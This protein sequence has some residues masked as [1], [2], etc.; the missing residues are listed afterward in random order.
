MQH[1]KYVFTLIA[2]ICFAGLAFA[3]TDNETTPLL[4]TGQVFDTDGNVLEG[5]VVEIWHTDVAGV[6]DHPGDGVGDEL[7]ETFQYFGTSTVDANGNY[8]FLTYKPGQYEPRPVH[9]HVKVKL[10]SVTALITQFYFSEDSTRADETIL[11][12]IVDTVDA[13]GEPIRV[14]IG[15]IVLD[16]NGAD[17]NTLVP[18][19]LQ[20]EGPF[21]PVVDI[22]EY[23]NDLTDSD[24]AQRAIITNRMLYTRLNVNTVTRD[25]LLAI[26]SIP[27]SLIDAI[28]ANRPFNSIIE[29]W[30]LDTE[31]VNLMDAY[32]YVPIDVDNTDA[33]TIMQLDLA[34]ES[35]EVIL[36]TLASPTNEQFIAFILEFFPGYTEDDIAPYLAE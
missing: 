29:L 35:A 3:Q 6:Y 13:Q 19:A 7:D 10:E 36:E 15:D 12:D 34:Q 25:E 11:L 26:E 8:A 14:A 21:Y 24:T 5:A 30:A 33:S 17:S 31:L 32:L 20:A 1:T 22:S 28:E 16:L 9:I 23:D 4:L 27:E 2:L 18:T